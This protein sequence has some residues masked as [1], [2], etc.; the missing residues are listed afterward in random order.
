MGALLGERHSSTT[1]PTS[2]SCFRMPL[3]FQHETASARGARMKKKGEREERDGK[4][5]KGKRTRT[6]EQDHN[7]SLP[8]LFSLCL[9]SNPLLSCSFCQST[10]SL[11]I[12]CV[13]SR[14]RSQKAG[15]Q[16][17]REEGGL[18]H[19]FP[20]LCLRLSF[21]LSSALAP[22]L[23]SDRFLFVLSLSL[24]PSLFFSIFSRKKERK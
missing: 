16:T 19:L 14:K 11:D 7:V 6:V 5:A 23:S 10:L 24:S 12:V 3:G 13:A 9:S 4:S 21:A 2:F 18:P 15:R 8:L 17:K 1:K 20:F 22:F